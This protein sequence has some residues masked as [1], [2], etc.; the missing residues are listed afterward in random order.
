M[1]TVSGTNLLDG[2]AGNDVLLG[3]TDIDVMNGGSGND[4]F[5]RPDIFDTIDGGDGIDTLDFTNFISNIDL[6]NLT[7]SNVEI[8]SAVHTNALDLTVN[9]DGVI[10]YTDETN[11]L[12]IIAEPND[13]ITTQS[14]WVYGQNEEID[15]IL[16]FKFTSGGA[17]LYIS[18]DIGTLNGFPEV[19]LGFS[20]TSSD[21][22]EADNNDDSI[23]G[24]S[25]IT[26][27]L[28]VTGKNGDDTITTGSGND[29][30]EGGAGSDILDGGAGIDTIVYTNSLDAVTTNLGGDSTGPQEIDGDTVSNFEILQG[31]NH[32]DILQT[33]DILTT[34]YGNDGSDV[35][36][37]RGQDDTIYGGAGDDLMYSSDGN[38]M[39]YGDADNDTFWVRFDNNISDTTFDGG[40]GTDILFLDYTPQ[41]P[42]DLSS[43]NVSNIE[44]IE[45]NSGNLQINFTLQD[46]IDFTDNNNQLTIAGTSNET[47]TSTGQ[48]WVQGSDQTIDG[49]VYNTY[50][51]GAGTLLVDEDIIQTI[52]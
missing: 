23:F 47:I 5:E 10:D 29:I 34:I 45:I 8:I 24:G 13:T 37:G 19:I 12:R 41:G 52:S 6:S 42:L 18:T 35:I 3:G 7:V 32:N 46:V 30:V 48:G 21:I 33:S 9:A 44:I 4:T 39:L 50:T 2:G 27:G 20:E 26:A 43:M 51:S 25:H 15:G 31:S 16:Y 1:N 49:E 22:W 28:T 36:Y 11:T 17:T 14:T 38:D 40:T